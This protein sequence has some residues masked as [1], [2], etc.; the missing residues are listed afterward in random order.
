M[1]EVLAH[2]T[3]RH[4]FAAQVIAL[5]NQCKHQAIARRSCYQRIY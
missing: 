5:L 3:Y 1:L 2:R 4:L